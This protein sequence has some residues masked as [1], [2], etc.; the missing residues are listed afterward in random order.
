MQAYHE[1]LEAQGVTL[2][3][4]FDDTIIVEENNENENITNQETEIEE[5]QEIEQETE[6]KRISYREYRDILFNERQIEIEVKIQ[7]TDEFRHIFTPE[8]ETL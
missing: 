4:P 8:T 1:Y 7:L 2:N 3:M 6:E 5:I